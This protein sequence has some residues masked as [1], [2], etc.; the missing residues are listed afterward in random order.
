MQHDVACW[1]PLI[2]VS[3]INLCHQLLFITWLKIEIYNTFIIE[4]CLV[5]NIV[6]FI[7]FEGL[8]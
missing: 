6:Y 5:Y 2:Q 1:L 8:L 4:L 7:L 3:V